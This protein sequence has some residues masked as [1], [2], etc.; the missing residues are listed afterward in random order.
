MTIGHQQAR[1]G[2]QVAQLTPKG[3]ALHIGERTRP[4]TNMKG[5]VPFISKV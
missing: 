4:F 3:R 2:T 5:C 1:D